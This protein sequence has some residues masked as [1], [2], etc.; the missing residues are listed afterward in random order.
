MNI[1]PYIFRAY[2]IRG[3]AEGPEADLTPQT[4]EAIGK[5]TGTYLIRK[6]NVKEMAIGR[7]NRTHSEKLH[8]AFIN[9]IISTG[10]RAI[11]IGIST[12]PLMYYAVSKFGYESGATI[13][14]SHNPKQDNG[15]K[16]VHAHA[17]CLAGEELQEILK[18]IEKQDYMVAAK[19]GLIVKNTDVFQT[20][21]DEVKSKTSLSRPLK[22]VVDTGN[23]VAGL[24]APAMLQELGCE[25][26]ELFTEL[27][28]NFPNHEA[29][30]E[31]PANMIDLGRKAVES[32]ADLGIGFDGDGDRLGVVDEKGSFH[33]IESPLIIMS[34]QMLSEYPGEKVIFDVKVSQKIIEDIEKNGGQ[35]IME[36]TG[37]SFIEE[38]VHQENAPLA[39]EKSGHVYCNKKFYDYFGFDDALFAA[40]KLVETLSKTNISFSEQLSD[41]RKLISTPEAKAKCPDHLKFEIIE[42][43][44]D[45]FCTDRECI[46]I[47]GARIK[48]DS[49]SWA[50]IRAS[51]TSPAFTLLFEAPSKERLDE[52]RSLVFT[53]LSKYPEVILPEI[54]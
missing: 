48:F 24:Y 26:I 21:K 53:E 14:A 30:P 13:T 31:Q 4:V 37:H 11:D 9:G 36:R 6:S 5:A 38:R 20:F 23:G 40:C 10:I 47:D 45:K 43:I 33:S 50:L 46:T 51:N 25:V 1:N 3:I 54:K 34:R 44:R 2:D 28:G 29:N 15:I 17:H 35:P 27:D 22:V 39:F 42:K 52:I 19:K 49:D 12:T 8:L 32:Q 7:D 41:V 18:I 16:L